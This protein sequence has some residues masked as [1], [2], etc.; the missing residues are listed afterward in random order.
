MPHHPVEHLEADSTAVQSELVT[1]QHLEANSEHVPSVEEDN[2]L[3][4][5]EVC[6]EQGSTEW[7]VQMDDAWEETQ[8]EEN[9]ANDLALLEHF[10]FLLGDEQQQESSN[11]DE[12]DPFELAREMRPNPTLKKST[13]YR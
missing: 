12:A 1:I 6:S 3:D 5:L 2:E 11:P 13:D 10:N 7:E 4:I 9:A 8:N